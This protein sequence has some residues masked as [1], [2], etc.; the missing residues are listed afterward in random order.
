MYKKIKNISN[1]DIGI[2]TAAVSDFKN[3][4]LVKKRLK[5]QAH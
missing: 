2:F 5:R 3:K 1:V 4:K